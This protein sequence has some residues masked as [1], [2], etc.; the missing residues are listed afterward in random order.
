MYKKYFNDSD[1]LI[2]KIKSI[3]LKDIDLQTTRNKFLGFI[4]LV[5]MITSIG[6]AF[7]AS[8]NLL[9]IGALDGVS[10]LIFRLIFSF[11][12]YLYYGRKV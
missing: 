1:L 7:I 4:C 2:N 5:F 9:L 12:Y 6:I 11:V 8:K 3:N 10:S